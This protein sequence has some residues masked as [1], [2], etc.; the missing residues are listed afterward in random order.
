MDEFSKS[1]IDLS[2]TVPPGSIA[3][4]GEVHTLVCPRT[5]QSNTWLLQTK[6]NTIALKRMLLDKITLSI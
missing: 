4:R 5:L 1:L 3:R 6:G 2:I